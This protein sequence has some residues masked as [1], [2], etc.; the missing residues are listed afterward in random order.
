[1]SNSIKL[2]I[3]IF[4]ILDVLITQFFLKDESIEKTKRVLAI[5]KFIVTLT[6]ITAIIALIKLW[7]FTTD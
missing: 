7:L 5:N 1:M 6:K 2:L 4:I 3:T